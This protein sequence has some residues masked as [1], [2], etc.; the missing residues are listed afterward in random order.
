ML[1]CGWHVWTDYLCRRTENVAASKGQVRKG[2]RWPFEDASELPTNDVTCTD[3]NWQEGSVLSGQQRKEDL[4]WAWYHPLVHERN[5]WYYSDDEGEGGGGSD[6]ISGRP[7]SD[8]KG[9]ELTSRQEQLEVELGTTSGRPLILEGSNILKQVGR[10]PGVPIPRH[11]EPKG[12]KSTNQQWQLLFH[13]KWR[14]VLPEPL[15]VNLKT[16]SIRRNQA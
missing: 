9:T 1:R 2:V 10:T 11:K 5:S 15:P 6:S 14:K 13:Q 7:E 4:W 8:D 12:R 16:R 3:A